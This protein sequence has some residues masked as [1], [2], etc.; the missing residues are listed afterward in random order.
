MLAIA[1]DHRHRIAAAHQ[2]ALVQ[3]PDFIAQPAQ[4][5]L[6]MGDQQNRR[7]LAAAAVEG[8]GGSFPR[9]GVVLGQRVVQQEHIGRAEIQLI[10]R[11]QVAP[12]FPALTEPEAGASIPAAA[13]SSARFP[14]P[15][16]PM[17]PISAEIGRVGGERL[18]WRQR[19][20][21]K[22]DCH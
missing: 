22:S 9:D 11:I 13:F 4:Q 16:S 14:D 10:R 17:I 1:V 20:L 3:P 2:L 21:L 6:F 19:H 18:Q 12:V 8:D 7:S 5:G 15:F